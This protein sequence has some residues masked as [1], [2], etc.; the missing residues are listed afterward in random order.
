MKRQ[1]TEEEAATGKHN[2]EIS[3][4]IEAAQSK[5]AY[6]LSRHAKALAPFVEAK[7]MDKIK[8]QRSPRRALGEDPGADR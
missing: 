3:A 8:A 7:V 5:R 4:A 6:Y 2:R 1:K